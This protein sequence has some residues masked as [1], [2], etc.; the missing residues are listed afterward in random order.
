MLIRKL[1]EASQAREVAAHLGDFIGELLSDPSYIEG[2]R[3]D[4]ITQ[5]TFA[6][7]S[8]V[9]ITAFWSL[10][11]WVGGPYDEDNDAQFKYAIQQIQRELL[12]QPTSVK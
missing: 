9:H 7:C 12:R 8:V 10:F 3:K 4:P 5:T 2:L 1:Q 11:F 6:I